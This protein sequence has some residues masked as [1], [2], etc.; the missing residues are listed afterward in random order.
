MREIKSNKKSFLTKLFIKLC[1]LFGFE[2]IDQSNY[3][4]PTSNQDLNQ[5]ISIPGERSVTLPL[6]KVKITRPVKS[7]DI[8]LRT[9][10]SVNMLTQSKRRIFEK[11]KDEYTKRTLFS[12][13]KSVHHA[14][15]IFKNLKFKIFIIDHNSEKNQIQSLKNM[16]Q[17]S[18]INFEILNLEVEKFSNQI[19][20]INEEN[21]EVTLNQK[22]NMSNIY[23]SLLISKEKSKDL[24]YF[25]EDDYIHE[26]NSLSEILHTYERIA[27]L[28][29]K[30]LIICPT[31]YPYLY[32]QNGSTRIFLGENRHWRQVD[33]S[34][35][36]F[37][38]SKHIVDKH[39]EEYVNMCKF[40]HYPFEKPLH[41]IYKNELCISPIP[42][43]AIH[44]TNI[45]SIYGLSPN[46]NWKRLWDENET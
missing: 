24:I 38:T 20:K 4:I 34:L 41:K 29:N 3:S 37:L 17:N 42:S 8:I 11:N 16:L 39:W 28:T 10:M 5:S 1:R 2:I 27:S 44:F 32:N 25:V 43:L 19:K 21:K 9:C 36:T 31:D 7:L 33:Q 45:N 26:L 35:C 6:G 30:D 14:Q 13:I 46:V 15:N 40:E 12:I 18:K 23:Q 22:S